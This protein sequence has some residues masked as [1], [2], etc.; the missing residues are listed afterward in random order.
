M[1]DEWKN[2]F[3]SFYFW[4]MSNGYDESAP[5]GKYEIDRIDGMKE[6]S[7]SNCRLATRTEQMNNISTNHVVTYNNESHTIADWSRIT[8]IDQYKIRNRIVRLGWPAGRALGF[9]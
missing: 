7:P 4:A 6:Y 9:E 1:C 2:D 8:G 3:M 5:R